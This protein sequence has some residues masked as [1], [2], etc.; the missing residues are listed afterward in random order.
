MKLPSLASG[1]RQ[2]G[3]VLV[4]LA[5]APV[6]GLA[7]TRLIPALGAEGAAALAQRLL[8]HSLQAGLAA[9]LGA[10]RLCVTPNTQH[11]AFQRWQAEAHVELSLQ[12]DGDLGQR[13]HQ[14]FVQALAH[15][16]QALMM[17]TD[18]PALQAPQLQAA[19]A[20]LHQAD[21]VLVPALDGGYAL[22]GLRQP[23]PSLF[24]GVAWSTAQ[25]L[26]QTLDRARAAGL[27]VAL[28]PA[29]ADI[30]E[31]ADLQH[32]PWPLEAIGP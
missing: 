32:L 20:A 30:D 24:Q 2:P 18:A 27:R 6:A 21:V 12:A 10:L 25:V 1:Q 28:L 14:A 23:A 4:V 7:K 19:A 11:P 17:G 26:Q 15:H 29:V 8:D 9:G 5:K 22:I 16:E 31:P 3:T 13:M